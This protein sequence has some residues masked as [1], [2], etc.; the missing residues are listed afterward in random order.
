MFSAPPALASLAAAKLR[1]MDVWGIRHLDMGNQ[2][3]CHADAW[4]RGPSPPR[5]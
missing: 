3:M 1:R 5:L 2:T 4:P